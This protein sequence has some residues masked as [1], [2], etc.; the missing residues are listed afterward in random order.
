LGYTL[1]A[2]AEA[3]GV[4]VATISRFE[5]EYGDTPLILGP[6]FDRNDGFAN[7]GYARAHHFED[8]A[9]METYAHAPDLDRWL[10]LLITRQRS[11]GRERKPD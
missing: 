6:N 2:I 4:S 3:S 7:Q 10:S 5:R 11:S 9:E 1:S 8:A